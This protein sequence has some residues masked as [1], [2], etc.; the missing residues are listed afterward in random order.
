MKIRAI[1][2][3]AAQYLACL[4]PLLAADL[5]R[6]LLTN[7]F[8]VD[9]AMWPYFLGFMMGLSFTYSGLAYL[10]TR[11]GRND[12]VFEVLRQHVLL[13]T[14]LV[15]HTLAYYTLK[16]DFLALNNGHIKMSALQSVVYSHWTPLAIYLTF[17][18]LLII[19]IIQTRY[20][21][22]EGPQS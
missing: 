18:I 8:S 10:T 4:V 12:D 21:R 16:P 9:R 3:G 19:R 17:Y 11:L 1:D 6:A 20:R 5:I 15:A 2:Q 22:C 7:H 13:G 14:V